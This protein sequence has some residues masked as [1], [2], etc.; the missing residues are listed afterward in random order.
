MKPYYVHGTS[1]EDREFF[2]SVVK[3]TGGTLKRY[4]SSIETE[5]YF[6]EKEMEDIVDFRFSLQEQTMPIYGFNSFVA[7]AEVLGRKVI[8]G[9]F[10]INFTEAGYMNK[11]LDS[12]SDSDYEISFSTL[13]KFCNAKSAPQFPKL[14]D[15]TI[16][17][18]Y[19]NKG[20]N[21]TYNNTHQI[22]KGVRITGMETGLD[23]SGNPIM[24]VYSFT[25]MDLYNPNRKVE[26]VEAEGTVAPI[27]EEYKWDDTPYKEIDEIDRTNANGPTSDGSKDK[28][29]K[30]VNKPSTSS[31][32]TSSS[33][34]SSA[35]SSS[36]FTVGSK[37]EVPWRPANGGHSIAIEDSPQG[38]TKTYVMVPVK[39]KEKHDAAVA[40][41]SSRRD[42]VLYTYE[43]RANASWYT[44]F[45]AIHFKVYTAAE[46]V[47]NAIPMKLSTD[48]GSIQ[49]VDSRVY[50]N[51]TFELWLK[52]EKLSGA[53][54]E[55]AL[56]FNYGNDDLEIKTQIGKAQKA[57][58]CKAV[59]KFKV[60]AGG[61]KFNVSETIYI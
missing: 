33:G 3:T 19:Y 2:T 61:Y 30:D 44:F 34:S 12:I 57:G 43:T 38:A 45:T 25:A 42:F 55:F 37:P 24:E 56:C 26:V 5:F 54:N 7:N 50:K 23:V 9:S 46:G 20:E 18:G 47:K 58:G 60:D 32:E 17:Y 6:G 1:L 8:Q 13:K 28:D 41:Y 40:R 16:G 27:E 10:A 11:V 36:S 49:I 53:E 22:L 4:F 39:D 29:N 51:K 15:I 48:R 35:S 31:K 59:I 21:G 52:Q 14:F